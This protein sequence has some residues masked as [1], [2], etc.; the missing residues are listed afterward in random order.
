MIASAGLSLLSLAVYGTR[1]LP[2]RPGAPDPI[3]LLIFAAGFLA[4]RRWK[5]NPLRVMFGAGI[6]GLILYALF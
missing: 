3:A 6:A 5:V 2:V 1:S 4:L